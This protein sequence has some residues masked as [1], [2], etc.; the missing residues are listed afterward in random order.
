[1]KPCRIQL[2]R[3]RG[4]NLQAA[5]LALNGLPAVKVDRST[6][7]GNVFKL[8]AGFSTSAGVRIP[9]VFVVG[10][11]VMT[12]FG[13]IAEAQEHAVVC[14]HAWV[15]HPANHKFRAALA[16]LRGKN[17]GCWCK[18]GTPCHADVELEI[19]NS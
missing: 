18:A 16:L 17:L 19:A 9:Q 14:F 8:V 2:S 4:F 15:D 13:T 6:F 3:K 11:G 5:S 10:P 12:G 1:M 7:Y